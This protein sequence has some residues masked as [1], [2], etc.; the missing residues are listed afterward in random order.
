[1]PWREEVEREVRELMG[2]VGDAGKKG[3]GGEG[4]KL[5]FAVFENDGLVSPTPPVRRAIKIVV[6]RLKELGHT[7]VEWKPPSHAEIQDWGNRY[8]AFDGGRD[9]Q[10]AFAL[11]GEPMAPQI[12]LYKGLEKEFTGGQIAATNVKLRHLKKGYMDYWNSTAKVTG[13]GRPVDAVITPV[14]P[15]PAARRERFTYYGYSGWVNVVDYTS[16]VVPVMK[17]DKSVDGRDEGYRPLDERDRGVWEA[18]KFDM[19]SRT[20]LPLLRIWQ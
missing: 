2:G 19:H 6:D 14:A 5:C 7:V 11:S 3:E 4:G 17:A 1:M 16:V 13:M 9:I 8:M 20:F 12:A 15:W 18:C 10:S